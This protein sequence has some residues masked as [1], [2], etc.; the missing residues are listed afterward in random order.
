MHAST[1]VLA[2]GAMAATV[3]AHG[4][5]ST[6][7]VNGKA[8]QGYDPS[9]AY[10]SPV[11]E[12]PG[13]T[14]SNLDNGFVDPSSYSSDDIICHKE[15]SPGKAYVEAAAG[16]KLEIQWS[17][18]P[19]SHH[20]PIIN[21]IAACDGECTTVDKTSLSWVKF[22]A[23]GLASGSNPGTWATDDLISN[24]FT[25]TATLPAGLKAGN[26]VV[27]HEIIALHSASQDNGAQNYPQCFNVKVTGSGSTAVSGGTAATTFYKSDDAGIKFNLY[28]AFSDYPMPGPE[29]WSAAAAKVR[30]HVRDFFSA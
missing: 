23:D 8:F 19:D 26:Y 16:D 2:L 25:A 6:I 12:V 24:N 11:P 15:S 30:R 5:V 22:Q 17:T 29:L 7:T 4:H 3:A 14:A 20:G 1:S 18:W 27:R 10:Q 9:F 21:Y 28:A 13:W